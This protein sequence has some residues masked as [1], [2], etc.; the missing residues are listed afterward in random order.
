MS[1]QLRTAAEE[2]LMKLVLGSINNMH[3]K[4]L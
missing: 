2:S 1:Y 3:L 4:I